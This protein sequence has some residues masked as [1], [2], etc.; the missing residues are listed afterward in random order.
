MKERMKEKIVVSPYT[1]LAP[2]YDAVMHHVDYRR[3]ARYIHALIEKYCPGAHLVIDLSCGT[4]SCC[5][6]LAELG[7]SVVGID[8]SSSMIHA[9][10]KKRARNGCTFLCGDMVHPPVRTGADVLISLYD[11]INYLRHQRQ[12]LECL[13][14][15]F[16]LLRKGG[17]FIFDVSTVFN[18]LSEFSNY[19]EEHRV[20][21]G[22]YR[23]ISAFDAETSIQTNY[24]EIVLRDRPDFLFCETH[25]QVIRRLSEIDEM[26]ARSPFRKAASYRDFTFLTATEQC[27][28]VHYVLKRES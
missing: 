9:A 11:S 24:F 1:A 26:I 16:D 5:L 25:R 6:L 8:F 15:S 13:Q 17:I 28:R 22:R 10:R 14:N 7:Y 19:H 27:E 2:I 3:W 12:W 21:N 4:G 23:R 20:N 18:S